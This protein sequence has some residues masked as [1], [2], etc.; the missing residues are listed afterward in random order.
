V[1]RAAKYTLASGAEGPFGPGPFHPGGCTVLS[2][3]YRS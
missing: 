3:E 2:S 1:G